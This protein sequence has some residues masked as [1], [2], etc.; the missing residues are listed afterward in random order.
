MTYPFDAQD[1]EKIKK[2]LD[3][4]N[5][6]IQGK[7]CPKNKHLQA[8]QKTQGVFEG[9]LIQGRLEAAVRGAGR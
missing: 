1:Q 5:Q 6:V 3:L 2:A 4:V 7:D 9:L 8:L